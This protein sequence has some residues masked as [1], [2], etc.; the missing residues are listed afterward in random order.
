MGREACREHIDRALR[1]QGEK[2]LEGMR[3]KCRVEGIEFEG[4]IRCGPPDEEILG[5]IAA[6]GYDL[7]IMGSR[8]LKTWR[9]RWESVNLP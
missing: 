8:L 3:E 9:E 6:G 4:K 1:E 2:A 5:E 7:L